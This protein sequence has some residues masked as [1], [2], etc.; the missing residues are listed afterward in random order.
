MP[1]T[2]PSMSDRIT[3]SLYDYENVGEN[4]LIAELQVSFGTHLPLATQWLTLYGAPTL[5]NSAAERAMNAGSVPASHYRGQL[6]IGIEQ[7]SAGADAPTSVSS[8]AAAPAEPTAS[9]E[10]RVDA[11]EIGEVPRNGEHLCLE[12]RVCLLMMVLMMM[13]HVCM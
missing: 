9:Y 1:V 12:V 2:M 4:Q 3:I 5:G 13:L 11:M 8:I 6:L 10:L 7:T